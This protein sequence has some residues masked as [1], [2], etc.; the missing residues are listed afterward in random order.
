MD[1]EIIYNAV[2]DD[3]WVE[4]DRRAKYYSR[5]GSPKIMPDIYQA[6]AY[7][8][9]NRCILVIDHFLATDLLKRLQASSRRMASQV[10]GWSRSLDVKNNKLSEY[11]HQLQDHTLSDAE[12]TDLEDA[13]D[14]VTARVHHQLSPITGDNAIVKYNVWINTGSL[15]APDKDGNFHF[16]HYDSDEYMEFCLTQDWIRF[17]VWGAILYVNQP[18]DEQHFTV[19]DDQKINQTIRAVTNRLVIFDPTYM[20]K[21]IGSKKYDDSDRPRLVMVFNAWDYDALDHAIHIQSELK[22]SR[23]TSHE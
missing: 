8:K 3:S 1:R 21:V 13:I 10:G 22:P 18:G 5:N 11:K 19:F 6:S 7:R 4:A 17:P 20:H 16:W 2:E 15:P 12:R 23:G 9:L 14:E